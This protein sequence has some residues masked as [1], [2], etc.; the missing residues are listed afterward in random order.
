MDPVFNDDWKLSVVTTSG[1]FKG[2]FLSYNVEGIVNEDDYEVYYDEEEETYVDDPSTAHTEE[3]WNK[4]ALELVKK[5]F[6]K[7]A[8]ISKKGNF[9]ADYDSE[10]Y[11]LN[12]GKKIKNSKS[13]KF[14][15][16]GKCDW[17]YYY[18]NK[19]IWISFDHY[20]DSVISITYSINDN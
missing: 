18:K 3:E 17:V 19:L 9:E 15:K 14:D 13:I 16:E 4:L 5:Y 7:T 11:K 2:K 1:E 8:K 20:A 10:E 12:K 6:D